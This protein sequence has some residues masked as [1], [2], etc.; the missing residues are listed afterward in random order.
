MLNIYNHSLQNT[1]SEDESLPEINETAKRKLSSGVKSASK[2]RKQE[3]LKPPTTEELNR[4]RET[5]NLYSSNLIRLQIEEILSEISVKQRHLDEI[6]LWW[7]TFLKVVSNIDD[8]EK[9]LLSEIKPHT[10]KKLS[11]QSKFIN[12]LFDNKSNLP[13]DR[14]FQL[15]FLHPESFTIFGEHQFK[16][17]TNTDIQLNI[18]IKMPAECLGAKD[19]LNNRYFIKRHYYLLY[20]LYSIRKK[21]PSL[22]IQKILY[23]DLDFFPFIQISPEFSDKIKINVFITPPGNFF[24]LSRFLP[25]KNNIKYDFDDKFEDINAKDFGMSGTPIHNSFMAKDCTL[26]A[27]Y[28]CFQELLNIKNIQE[29]IQLLKIWLTQRQFNKGLG[30]FTN[31]LMFYVVAYLAKKKKI[32]SHMSS[33][34]VVRIFWSFIKDSNWDQEPISLSD[35]VKIDTMEMFKASYDVVFL[36]V[37]GF[38][39]ITSFLHLGVYLRLKQEAQL[40]LNILDGNK[41]N[42][43]SSLFLIKVPFILQYDALIM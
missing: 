41:F 36:D 32:N 33:Y 19:Y 40:A 6:D 4:L 24:N 12:E 9:I 34:Q 42:A 17:L 1:S 27:N 5:E 29:G 26:D 7:N 10:G 20:I 18:D 22:K 35:E 43:F 14:D 25:D 30:N 39:N 11:K 15:R 38:F 3:L 8:R 16:C 21:I 37:T 2:K 31:E 28:Q 23:Q 13:Y